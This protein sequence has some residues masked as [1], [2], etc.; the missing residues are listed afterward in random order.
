MTQ[1]DLLELD[2]KSFFSNDATNHKQD[3]LIYNC[4]KLLNLLFESEI[5]KL[6]IEKDQT[7]E[8]L[9]K[10]LFS[11]VLES[12]KNEKMIPH[13][14]NE[15]RKVMSEIKY[16]GFLT[17]LTEAISMIS[18]KILLETNNTNSI[19]ADLIAMKWELDIEKLPENDNFE[20]NFMLPSKIKIPSPVSIVLE[21]LAKDP[22]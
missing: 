14:Y 4:S 20:S 18:K 13:D 7:S 22:C 15:G 1:F 12:Q 9:N 21:E 17:N 6:Y 2:C 19:E 11:S 10:F 16:L 8:N 5:A 3:A